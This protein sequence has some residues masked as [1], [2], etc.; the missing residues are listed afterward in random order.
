M[1]KRFSPRRTLRGIAATKEK[2]TGRKERKGTQNKI[3]R[4]I[5][6][7]GVNHDSPL[8]CGAAIAWPQNLPK[9]GK[10]SWIVGSTKFE[11]LVIRTFGESFLVKP[12]LQQTRNKS[13]F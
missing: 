13:Y 4:R 2:T 5:P 6:A 12:S 3:P 8:G 1:G 11:N 9:L 10:L 7:V